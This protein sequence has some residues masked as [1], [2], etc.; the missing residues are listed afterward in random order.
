MSP[1]V[2]S[3]WMANLVFDTAGQL[4]FK[5]AAQEHGHDGSVQRWRR[6]ASQPWLWLGLSCY[7]AEFLLWLAFL[8]LVPLSEG[9][10]LGSINIV[11]IMLA[12]RLLFGE[13]LSRLRLSGILLISAGVALVGWGA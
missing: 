2:T 5:R 1:L 3:L 13:R 8:S 11:A 7:V 6:M 9:V 10:L 12:G 4:I